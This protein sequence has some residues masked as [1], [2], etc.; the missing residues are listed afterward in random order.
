MVDINAS[1]HQVIKFH[2]RTSVF[3]SKV[4]YENDIL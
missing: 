2:R 1:A 4:N 3:V